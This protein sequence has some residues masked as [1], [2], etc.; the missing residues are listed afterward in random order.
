MPDEILESLWR[1]PGGKEL[2]ALHALFGSGSLP[3]GAVREALGLARE[4]FEGA[5]AVALAAGLVEV[6]EESV[7]LIPF[8]PDSEPRARLDACLETHREE[9]A[10]LVPRMNRR[11][12]LS[13]G[14]P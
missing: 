7:V 1:L 5:L 2:V 6:H 3:A 9:W 11:V 12:L 8:P 14:F 13:M 10:A 4:E